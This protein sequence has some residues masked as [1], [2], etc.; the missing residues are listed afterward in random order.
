MKLHFKVL[1]F[2][3]GFGSW[4][5]TPST[6]Q[7]STTLKLKSFLD[8]GLHIPFAGEITKMGASK[9]AKIRLQ[10]IKEVAELAVR[11]SATKYASKSS[12]SFME[13]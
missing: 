5:L 13:K 12:N 7:K 11:K 6:D 9:D 3:S 8:S 1:I 2:K 4:I 10:H